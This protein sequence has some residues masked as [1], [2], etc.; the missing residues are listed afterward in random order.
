MCTPHETCIVTVVL[1]SLLLLQSK[2]RGKK[3]PVYLFIKIWTLTVT[4]TTK[5]GG[6]CVNSP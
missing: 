3:L 2:K 5:Y 6:F 4:C 1:L